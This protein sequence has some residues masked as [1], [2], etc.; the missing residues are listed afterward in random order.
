LKPPD[1]WEFD[2]TPSSIVCLQKHVGRW[3]GSVWP[4]SFCCNRSA[5]KPFCGETVFLAIDDTLANKRGHKVFGTFRGT[6]I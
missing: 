3:T 4:C 2:I 1:N 6:A 5:E